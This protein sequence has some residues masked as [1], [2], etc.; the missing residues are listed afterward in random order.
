M[1]MV[2]GE[3]ADLTELSPLVSALSAIYPANELELALTIELHE[4]S[5]WFETRYAPWVASV[6]P[7]PD[8]RILE[9]GTGT[10]ASGIPFAK[11]GANVVGVDIHQAALDVAH[12][13]AETFGVADRFSTHCANG[14]DLA[15]VIDLQTFDI[16]LFSASLEH[17]TYS[18]RMAALKAAWLSVRPDGYLVIV[19][20]PNRLWFF[21]NHT[22]MV[23]FFHWLPDELASAYAKR[24][25]RDGDSM[26]QFS[27]KRA[28]RDGDAA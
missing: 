11:M 8:C 4:R 10:G 16:A 13:R 25:P 14:A 5:H 7:L 28:L 27:A 1:S 3:R 15:S 21:D 12:I 20:S 22:A 24:A 17:M 26:M 18:E 23:N 6:F 9:I 19:D 2:T